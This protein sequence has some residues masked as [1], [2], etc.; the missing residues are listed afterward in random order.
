V[1]AR[2]AETVV[3]SFGSLHAVAPVASTVTRPAEIA[4]SR[5]FIA[6]LKV[7]RK[8]DQESKHTA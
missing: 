2:T 4:S 7:E 1:S 3:F 8:V 6:E 5:D